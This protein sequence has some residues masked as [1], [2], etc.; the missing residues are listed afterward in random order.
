[1]QSGLYGPLGNERYGD[2][3]RDIGESGRYLLGVI[4]D[5]LDMSSLEAGRVKLDRNKISLAEVIDAAAQELTEATAIKNVTM[6]I[7]K[8][9][10][11]HAI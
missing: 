4:S 10:P 6:T 9:G 1:M 2:Y 7:K 11:L 8:S 5:I 3:S